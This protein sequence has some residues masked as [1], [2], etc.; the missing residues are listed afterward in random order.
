[1][2]SNRA[3]EVSEQAFNELVKAVEAGKNQKL[4]E[5]LKAMGRFHN[6]SL[7][8]AILIELRRRHVRS[9]FDRQEQLEEIVEPWMV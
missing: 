9:L 3:K 8:N 7:G 6:Y 2:K 5:Y 1:M 4:V